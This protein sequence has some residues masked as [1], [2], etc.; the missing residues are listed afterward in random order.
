MCL[1]TFDT[2]RTFDIFYL[3]S[4][5]KAWRP[6]RYIIVFFSRERIKCRLTFVKWS[7]GVLDKT[8]N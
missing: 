5:K 8:H 7:S 2:L 3:A 1:Y 6:L 4:N